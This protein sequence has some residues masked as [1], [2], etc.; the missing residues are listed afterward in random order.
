MIDPTFR[1]INIL[2]NLS[3][4]VGNN[5]FTRNSFAKYYMSLEIKDFNASNDNNPFFDQ[6]IKT[7]SQMKN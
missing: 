1:N 3:F 5:D 2:F 4:E 7:N 6:P